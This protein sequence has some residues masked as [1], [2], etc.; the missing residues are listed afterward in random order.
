M[1]CGLQFHWV[2]KSHIQNQTLGLDS[3]IRIDSLEAYERLYRLLSA[4]MAH[5]KKNYPDYKSDLMDLASDY[6]K[7]WDELGD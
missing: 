7:A 5:A 6:A 2:M 3:P 1:A 4:M